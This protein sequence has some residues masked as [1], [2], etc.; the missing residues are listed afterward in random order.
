MPIQICPK[1][2]IRYE[3]K[4]ENLEEAK[5]NKIIDKEYYAYIEQHLS[6]ICSDKCWIS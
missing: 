4:F 3:T 6:G 2:E 1:C 5:K